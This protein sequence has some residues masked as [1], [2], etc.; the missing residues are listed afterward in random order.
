MILT[1][2]RNLRL[3]SR[4]ERA[5]NRVYS[6][7]GS[8]DAAM[9]RRR[10]H[11]LVAALG[12]WIVVAA[13]SAQAA[14]SALAGP[15][16]AYCSAGG[17]LGSGDFVE[18]LE[19]SPYF[20]AATCY[21]ND[22]ACGSAPNFLEDDVTG[23]TTREIYGDTSYCL[24]DV[25]S[26]ATLHVLGVEGPNK[27]LTVSGDYEAYFP[28]PDFC[29]KAEVAVIRFSGDP[30][31]LLSLNPTSVGDLVEVGLIQSSDI[32]FVKDQFPAPE[33]GSGQFDFDVST[34]GINENQVYLLATV[35]LPEPSRFTLLLAGL[36][37]LSGLKAWR[38]S[39]LH[40]DDSS[41]PPDRL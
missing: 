26:S 11:F 20:C 21:Y 8:R 31:G 4:R 29:G 10:R 19:F 33:L 39:H 34:K 38:S 40:Q 1:N 37:S 6:L 7:T 9:T 2:R 24:G 15:D 41:L 13:S 30:L 27:L 14:F 18:D 25:C 23:Q 16:F 12:A 32:L 28:C 5:R 35:Q 3:L 17:T 22:G 36:V